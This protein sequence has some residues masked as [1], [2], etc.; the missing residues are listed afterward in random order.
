GCGGRGT[1]AA[2]QTL[3]ADDNVVLT[4]MAD[5]F[6]DKLQTSLEQLRK[7]A[8]AKVKVEQDHC[9]VG[10]DAFQ[11]LIES[12]V[13]VIL[14]ATPPGFRPQHLKAAI[15]AGKHVFC[16]KPVATD[17]PGIRSVFETVALAKEKKLALVSGF[18]WRYNLAEQALFQRILDGQIGDLRAIYNTYYTGT[19][20]PMPPASQRPAGSTDLDW[21]LRNWYNFNWLSGDGYVEQAVHAVDWM[22][23][24]MRDEPPAKAVAVGGRQIP[25]EGG[26]IFDHFAV[27]Y[28]YA[29]GARGFLASRQQGGCSNDNTGTF[30]GTEGEARELG[31]NGMPFIRG[32]NAWKYAGPRPDMYT[33]EHQEMY[34]SIRAGNPINNGERMT[35]TTLTA[36][37]GRMAAYT[38]KE[39][40]WDMALNSQERLVPEN[41]TWDM[42]IP[43]PPIAKPGETQ[44]T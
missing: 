37:M 1:G 10:L 30:I 40:T 24:A 12:D 15:A 31:F 42:S 23:W 9:F 4:A 21:Q 25:S 18:C 35:R 17:A 39:I 36:L 28:E 20:R 2:S 6:Q 22:C 11:K 32:R 3:H 33:V 34:K 38:G 16:E 5:V 13:D 26:N 41:I 27:N 14:L 43:V 29:N 7:E 8:P 44:F 19:V